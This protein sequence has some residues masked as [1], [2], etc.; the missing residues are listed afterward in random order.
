MNAQPMKTKTNRY[1][2]RENRNKQVQ[3]QIKI[4]DEDLKNITKIGKYKKAV[5]NNGHRTDEDKNKQ[6]HYHI[7][8]VYN[9]T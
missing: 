5:S 1:T 4:H 9:T 2:T 3:S 6:I 7:K 8:R